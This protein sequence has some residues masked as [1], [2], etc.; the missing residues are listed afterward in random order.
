MYTKTIKTEA[1]DPDVRWDEY[2]RSSPYQ[3]RMPKIPEIAEYFRL[4]NAIFGA[5]LA[6]TVSLN[7]A[8][9]ILEREQGESARTHKTT[10]ENLD[11]QFLLFCKAHPDSPVGLPGPKN[12]LH[13][14]SQ[15]GFKKKN[16]PGGDNQIMAANM[17]IVMIYTY[18]EDHYRKKIASAAGIKNKNEVKSEIMSDLNILRNSII[19]HRGYMKTDKKCKILTWFQPGDK[20]NVD[21]DRFEEIKRQIE[22]G[23]SKLSYELEKIVPASEH[24]I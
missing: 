6:I 22:M 12:D 24:R 19:H 1:I 13:M 10:I 9:Q 7:E 20:I 18:W 21:L 15:G 2:L 17:C 16:A 11:K 8:V 5:Y 23:L 14:C 3:I 4:V